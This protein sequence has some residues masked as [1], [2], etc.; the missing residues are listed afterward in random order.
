MASR[1]RTSSKAARSLREGLADA[2]D[3]RGSRITGL[4]DY[5][6][7]SGETEKS[8][9]LWTLMMSAISG[10]TRSKTSFILTPSGT[11]LLKDLLTMA[12]SFH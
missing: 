4:K 11:K 2:R 7:R 12:P 10:M 3:N 9:Q 5:I 6:F 8:V 1:P